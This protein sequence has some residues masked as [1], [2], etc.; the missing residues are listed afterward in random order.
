MIRTF[1]RERLGAL[2]HFTR[3]RGNGLPHHAQHHMLLYTGLC[4]EVEAVS[5]S[6]GSSALLSRQMGKEEDQ[7]AVVCGDFEVGARAISQRFTVDI[8]TKSRL[9]LMPE[10]NPRNTH[11]L[12]G[13][14]LHGKHVG[15]ARCAAHHGVE[16]KRVAGKGQGVC[17]RGAEIVEVD[18]RH[19]AAQ[20]GAERC[21]IG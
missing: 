5:G 17:G 13:M 16:R 20:Q 1:G 19:H 21:C 14:V 18:T 11:C 6:Y 10:P 12:A 8:D 2:Y 4:D 3:K 9:R 15:L 7:H